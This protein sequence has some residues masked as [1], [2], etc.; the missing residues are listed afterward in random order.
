MQTLQCKT[1]G[2]VFLGHY[3]SEASNDDFKATATKADNLHIC[4]SGH[5]N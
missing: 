3:V 4:S 2:E 1:R 5:N